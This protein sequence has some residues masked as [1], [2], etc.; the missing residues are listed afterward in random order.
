ML[1]ASDVCAIIP[2][3]GDHVLTDILDTLPYSDVIIWN[4]LERGSQGCYSRYLA[5]QEATQSVIYFQDD[6]LIFTAHKELLSLYEP[7]KMIVNMPSPWHEICG[8]DKLDQALVGAGSL[9]DRNLPFPALDRYL[10]EYPADELFLDY[11]DVIVGMLTPYVRYDLGYQVLP[12]ASAPDRIYTK[13]GAAERK[14]EMQRRVIDLREKGI[15][16][17]I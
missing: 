5:I 2:T 6:D 4:D 10:A 1:S 14:A 16:H 11:C 7:G 17:D 13:P 15:T 3:R 9:L 12:Y 8:Y